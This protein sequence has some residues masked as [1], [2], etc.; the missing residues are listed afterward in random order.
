MRIDLNNKLYLAPEG[1]ASTRAPKVCRSHSWKTETD[2]SGPAT[3]PN[4]PGTVRRRRGTHPSARSGPARA[5][6]R[7]TLRFG[8][9]E[10]LVVDDEARGAGAGAGQSSSPSRA[11]ISLNWAS[12]S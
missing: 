8:G 9:L 4:L 1:Y 11:S 3:P 10:T 5:N 12:R 7:R 2:A 6:A